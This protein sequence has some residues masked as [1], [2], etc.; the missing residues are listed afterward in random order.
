MAAKIRLKKAGRRGQNTF[1][2]VVI[3]ESAA[4]N[5]RPIEELGSFNPHTD[6]ISL[7]NERITEWLG[8]GA[9]LSS[10]ARSVINKAGAKG[11]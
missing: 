4:R 5:G 2:L 9:Q 6:E 3:D 10:R 1:R 11:A 7:N 8:K